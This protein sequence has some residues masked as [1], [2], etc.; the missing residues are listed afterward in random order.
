[1]EANEEEGL[2]FSRFEV[3]KRNGIWRFKGLNLPNFFNKACLQSLFNISC[4]I[5][6]FNSEWF[7]CH[8]FEAKN[9]ITIHFLFFINFSVFWSINVPHALN[10]QSDQNVWLH[11]KVILFIILLSLIFRSTFAP[12]ITKQI[13][14]N[15]SFFIKKFDFSIET[16]SRWLSVLKIKFKQLNLYRWTLFGIL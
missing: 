13:I 3:Q 11:F 12:L 6:K 8:D 16:Y 1:M 7:P 2:N 15:I 4:Q 10:I 9:Y 14:L 5:K